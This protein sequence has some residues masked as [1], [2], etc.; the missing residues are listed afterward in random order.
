MANRDRSLASKATVNHGREQDNLDD[1]Y[2]IRARR[3][4][5]RP[6]PIRLEIRTTTPR[7]SWRHRASSPSAGNSQAA[8][9]RRSAGAFERDDVGRS[10]TTG[11]ATV[12]SADARRGCRFSR[13][14]APPFRIR[15]TDQLGRP[16][17]APPE[18][19]RQLCWAPSFPGELRLLKREVLIGLSRRRVGVAKLHVAEVD[20]LDGPPTQECGLKSAFPGRALRG[21]RSDRLSVSVFTSTRV[22]SASWWPPSRLP[23]E[24]ARTRHISDVTC[25]ASVV[26]REL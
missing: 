5:P 20:P 14:I 12:I 10:V 19:P 7:F 2:A 4:E 8:S 9:A 26:G 23:P 6:Q 3:S 24:S 13:R 25:G 21:R 15:L 16:P 22:S 18:L 17:L 1:G 11:V